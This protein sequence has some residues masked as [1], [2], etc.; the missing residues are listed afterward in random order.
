VKRA[1]AI[2]IVLTAGAVVACSALTSL[3]DLRGTDAAPDVVDASFDALTEAAPTPFC[4]PY[5]DA[6]LT[7]CESFDLVTDGAALALATGGDATAKIDDSDFTSPPA[8]LRLDVSTTNAPSVKAYL[9][10]SIAAEPSKV[11]VDFELEVVSLANTAV[12]VAAIGIASTTGNRSV[13]AIL[14]VT[15]I[16]LQESV[17]TDAGTAYIDHPY[18]SR[19]WDHE[20]HAIEIVLDLGTKT[21]SLA[22]DGATLEANYALSS[23]WAK[24]LFTLNIGVTYANAP[25]AGYTLRADDVLAALSL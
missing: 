6:A 12:N 24:G 21:T 15:G 9:T 2:A 22:I 14:Y 16:Q 17:P 3:D 20:W 7:Y 4:A 10:H 23:G 13:N 19:T 11:V 1:I 5:V 8:S 18:I 25:D